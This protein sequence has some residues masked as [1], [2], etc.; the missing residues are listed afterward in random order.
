MTGVSTA[1]LGLAAQSETQANKTH[2]SPE[3]FS[4]GF[5]DGS[6]VYHRVRKAARENKVSGQIYKASGLSW[7]GADLGASPDHD[8]GI[9]RL[10]SHHPALNGGHFAGEHLF[11]E[12][13]TALVSVVVQA[14]K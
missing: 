2:T 3:S 13:I 1:A 4:F 14:V 6:R 7:R 9:V 10:L 8:W 5:I 12:L 11:G